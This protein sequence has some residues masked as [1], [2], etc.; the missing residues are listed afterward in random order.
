MGKQIRPYLPYLLCSGVILVTIDF[1]TVARKWVAENLGNGAYNAVYLLVA[2]FIAWVI[3]RFVKSGRAA[4]VR[5]LLIVAAGGL[6]A[7]ALSRMQYAVEKIHYV[8]YG[9]LAVLAFRAVSSSLGGLAASLTALLMVSLTGITDEFLQSLN[10]DRVGEF[11]D[12]FTDLFAGFLGLLL[13]LP[14]EKM[15]ARFFRFNPQDRKTILASLG[16]LLLLSLTFIEKVHGYGY[17]I[18]DPDSI[19]F[20]SSLTPG[21]SVVY[22]DEA[23]RHAIQRDFYRTNR[24]RAKDGSYYYEYGKSW[25]ENLVLERYYSGWLSRSCRAWDPQTREEM[26]R[27]GEWYLGTPWT[28]RVKEKMIVSVPAWPLRTGLSACAA[29]CWALA[30]QPFRRRPF[31]SARIS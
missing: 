3:I 17:L 2:A 31:K 29:L 8:E 14:Q 28:S 15:E 6:Y 1:T 5:I 25:K 21:D 12:V 10:T 18:R 9:L 23:E 7:L 13:Y 19:A 22:D 24:F 26:R 27:S 20:F 11:R 16:L 4:P 30:F